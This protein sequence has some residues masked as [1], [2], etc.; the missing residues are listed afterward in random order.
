MDNKQKK[1]KL[2]IFSAPSGSGKSTIINW[3]MQEH[4]DWSNETIAQH[5]GFNDRS[6]F[7]KKFK[8]VVGM[9]P[10]E[11]QVSVGVQKE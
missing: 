2:L 1:G 8:E 5:C 4:P 7:H 3:L 9:S 6:Y 10:A 11:Y